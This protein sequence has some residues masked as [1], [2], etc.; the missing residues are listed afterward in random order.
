MD[1]TQVANQARK[2]A[3]QTAQELKETGQEWSEKA[4]STARDAGAAA[5][6]YLREYAWTSVIVIAAVAGLLGYLMGA[7]RR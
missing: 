3:E 2:T 5:D 1:T 4:K 7:Q 6:L